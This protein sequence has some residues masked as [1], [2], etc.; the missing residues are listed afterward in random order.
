MI[1]SSECVVSF[2]MPSYTFPE[3]DSDSDRSVTIELQSEAE[4][5]V[6]VQVNVIAFTS[7]GS[8]TEATRN[9]DYSFNDGL[10]VNFVEGEVRSMS[11]PLSILADDLVERREGFTLQFFRAPDSPPITD[12]PNPTTTVFIDD[13]DGKYLTIIN[14]QLQYEHDNIGMFLMN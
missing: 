11:I 8:V 3:L 14:Q 7:G 9:Q 2:Q 5:T 13:S 4:V 10:F 6:R 12:G 1:D